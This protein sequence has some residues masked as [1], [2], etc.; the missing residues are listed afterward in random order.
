MIQLFKAAG[1]S[2]SLCRRNCSRISGSWESLCTG[3]VQLLAR[4][5][6][7][8]SREHQWTSCTFH[9]C[10]SPQTCKIHELSE[11]KQTRSRASWP[12]KNISHKCSNF[13]TSNNIIKPR[14][15]PA[16]K[17]DK[18]SS[19]SPLYTFTEEQQSHDILKESHYIIINALYFSVLFEIIE[20]ASKSISCLK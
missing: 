12:F 2:S 10:L 13:E 6:G 3:V 19:G 8:L 4:R 1:D 17:P 16:I 20:N 14:P 11:N 9:L 7:Q 18:G 5:D 15:H